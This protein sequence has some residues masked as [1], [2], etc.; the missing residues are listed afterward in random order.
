MDNSTPARR[1]LKQ[2]TRELLE[3]CET[4]NDLLDIIDGLLV[5]ASAMISVLDSYQKSENISGV[6]VGLLID[7]L[8]E[9]MRRNLRHANDAINQFNKKKDQ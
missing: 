6:N 4:P 3:Q 7:N 2:A 1:K 5:S 8:P 9:F